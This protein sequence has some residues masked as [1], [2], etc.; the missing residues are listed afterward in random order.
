MLVHIIFSSSLLEFS[1]EKIH[2][3]LFIKNSFL[4]KRL[5]ILFLCSWYPSEVFPTNGDF[6]QRHAEAVNREHQVSVLHIVSNPSVNKT[7]IEVTEKGSFKMY[8][9]YIK[10]SRFFFIKWIRFWFAYK[11]IIQ[12][13]AEI[14]V[15]HVNRIFP[16]GIF[17]LF[18]KSKRKLNY[19]I[20]EHWTGYHFTDTKPLSWFEKM[21]SKRIVKNAHFTCPVSDDL[22]KS[23]IKTGLVGNYI[24]VPNVVDTNLFQPKETNSGQFT[25]THISDLNDE[26]KNISGMLRVANKLSEKLNDF[27]WNFIGG[28][29]DAYSKL[30][31]ELDFHNAK[32]NFID[33]VPH[34]EIVS[35]LNQSDVFVL[36]SNYENLPC[37]ILEAF[38]SGTPVISTN[39]GGIKEYF[40]KE[41][42]QLIKKGD[43]SALLNALV[44]LQE[45][46]IN[47]SEEMHKY[48]VENFSPQKICDS[49]TK[50]YLDALK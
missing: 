22:K 14:D 48:A 49:F 29:R 50:L 11:K 34:Q 41:F 9:A 2:V 10:P 8:I 25:I 42:G 15:V 17:A 35:Y 27:T 37:V 23:M 21:I 24:K 33:H 7:E 32:I 20:S 43:E 28:K 4:K 44:G 16:L 19:I 45:L 30:L 12:Q 1:N 31:S 38:S 39:V 40:P 36:F 18:L 26:H 6:I 47:K 3:L 13:I 5:H 46:P